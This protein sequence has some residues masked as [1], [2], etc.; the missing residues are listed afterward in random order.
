MS[1]A[2]AL[3]KL[4]VL[5]DEKNV[6]LTLV[7]RLKKEKF[8]VIWATTVAQALAQVD[9]EKFDLALLDVG[10][11]DGSGFGVAEHLRK[12]Q[13]AAAVIFLTAFGNPE[14]RVKGLELGAEDYIV[15]PFH[16]K[17]LLLRI[18]NGLKR[19]QYLAVQSPTQ[20]EK[21]TL[22]KAV[23]FLSR[24]QAEVGGEVISLTHKEVAL[25][26]LLLERRGEVVSRDEILNHVWSEEE[27]PSSRTVDNFI[28]RLRRLI[29]VNSDD[30]QVIKSVRGVGYQLI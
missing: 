4:L 8:Q 11:P 29:E 7:E 23:F 1:E 14:D 3:P 13:P 10:L 30:P 25:L 12:I 6:G 28:V 16:L 17:E 2:A 19:A 22:G 5:E 21:L 18:Q 15:K 26:K 20:P 9:R 24:F 27:F